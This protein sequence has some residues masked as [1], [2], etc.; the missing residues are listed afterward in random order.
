MEEEPNSIMYQKL[1]LTLVGVAAVAL[2]ACSGNGSSLPTLQHNGT[3]SIGHS[4]MAQGGIDP[5][6]VHIMRTA[7]MPGPA[8]DAPQTLHYGNGAVEHKAT[9]YVVYWGFNVS[10]SDPSGEQA[11]M[12][13]FLNGVG[14]SAWLNT[15]HQYYEI[16]NTKTL[17]ILNR[18]HQ[19]KGTW[20]DPSTVP[21]VPTDSQIQAEAAAAEGHFGY[22]KDA[23]YVVATPHNHN[24]A[25]FGIQYC[26]YHGAANSGGGVIAY[27]NLPYMTDAGQSCGENA[28]NPGSKGILDGVSI[29]EGHELAES[30]TDPHPSNGWYNFSYGEIGDICAWQGLG[31]T[32][33]TTGTFAVQPLWSNSASACVL[34]SP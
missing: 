21:S 33:L 32:V 13:S 18:S 7:N 31:N 11:Y 29:V 26:A 17:Y 10:G 20:V 12:T 5:S 23:S 30:Q 28:V 16:V 22:H 34:H 25:G 4:F 9:I 15:D 14:K 6:K 19:L 27:T 8:V 2:A 1:K 3:Q 24:S